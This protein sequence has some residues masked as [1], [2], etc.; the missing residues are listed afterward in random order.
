MRFPFSFTRQKGGTGTVLGSDSAP[1]T[2][3]PAKADN[4]F[5]HITSNVN[6]WPAQRIAMVCAYAGA[7]A[8]PALPVQL[9]FWEAT[10][11]R[12]YPFG[13]AVNLTPNGE[14]VFFD[15]IGALEYI[16]P[17]QGLD[18]PKPGAEEFFVVVGDN[19][20]PAG[21]YTFALCPDLTTIGT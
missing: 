3:P 9:Y 4:L 1:T 15:A 5:S 12:W 6:G 7:G 19:A 10:T 18:S 13:G 21:T 14:I 8:A 11:A 2:A 17:M 16:G 20:A